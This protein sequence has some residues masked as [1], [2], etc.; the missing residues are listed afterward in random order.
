MEESKLKIAIFT[1]GFLPVPAVRG[2]GVETLIT[3]FINYNE[4]YQDFEITVYT[5]DDIMLNK[6]DFKLTKLILVN[7]TK[8]R[9]HLITAINLIY[10]FLHIDLQYGPNDWCMTR[11]ICDNYDIVIVENNM[12][13]FK[14]L[15]REKLNSKFVFHL[16]NS[17]IGDPAK[18]QRYLKYICNTADKTIAVSEYIKSQF[19]KYNN[20]NSITLYNGVDIDNFSILDDEITNNYRNKLQIKQD[21]YV[22]L[23]CGRLDKIKGV[24][25][26][27]NSVK[28]LKESNTYN[29]VKLLIAGPKWYKKGEKFGKIIQNEIQNNDWIIYLGSVENKKMVYYYNLAQITVVPSIVDEAF[30][31]TPLESLLCGTPVIASNIGGLKEVVSEKVG[32]LVNVNGNFEKNLESAICSLINDQSL[33]SML[34]SNTRNYAIS[35]FYSSEVYYKKFKEILLSMSYE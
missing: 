24:L 16:H 34:K 15:K 31:L 26:L 29:N 25:T 6:Y 10:K 21:D 4:I 3:N 33:Y 17:S 12:H 7:E 20:K 1:P 18:P 30:G 19:D 9:R 28:S 27:I 23:Y 13:V 5:P 35:K 14:L 22:L 2:G 11:E 32:L 8:F